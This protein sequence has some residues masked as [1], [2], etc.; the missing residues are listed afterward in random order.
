MYSNWV[1][2]SESFVNGKQAKNFEH[3]FFLKKTW[4]FQCAL[5]VSGI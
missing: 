1:L 3:G 2:K 5:E 4:F